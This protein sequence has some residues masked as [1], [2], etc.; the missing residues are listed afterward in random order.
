M[1]CGPRWRAPHAPAGLS[2]TLLAGHPVPPGAFVV[3]MDRLKGVRLFSI[4]ELG[5]L[6]QS[7]P[8]FWQLP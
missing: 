5:C 6:D 7:R 4:C 2:T 8:L 3:D 1:D